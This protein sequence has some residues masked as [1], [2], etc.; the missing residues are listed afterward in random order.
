MFGYVYPGYRSNVPGWVLEGL[1][2]KARADTG[3]DQGEPGFT[4]GPLIS[5]FSFTIDIREWGFSSPREEL[6]RAAQRSPAI[7]AIR[8]ADVWDERAVDTPTHGASSEPT[9]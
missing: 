7:V 8:D 6:V 3:R 4:R 5:K 9:D 1:L 2:E